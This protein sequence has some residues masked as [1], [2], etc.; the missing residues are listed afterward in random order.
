MFEALIIV[1]AKYLIALPVLALLAYWFVLSQEKRSELALLAV[2][3]LPLA[4]L[5]ARIAGL[6]YFHLQPFVLEN[7]EPLVPHAA[8]NAFPSDH[9]AFAGALATL[10]FFYNR[11]LGATLGLVA[12]CIGLTRILAG[13]HYPADIILGAV[14]GIV[15]ALIA[16]QALALWL[17]A[18]GRA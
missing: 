11:W 13:L 1:G 14:F 17:R 10:A 5:I 3:A 2:I 12:L 7:F 4:Y 18:K 9:V 6:F 15:A 16:T 8:D